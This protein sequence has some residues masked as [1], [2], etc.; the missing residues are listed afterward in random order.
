M[1]CEKTAQAFCDCKAELTYLCTGCVGSHWSTPGRHLVTS[2][3]V[4]PEAHSSSLSSALDR[5]KKITLVKSFLSERLKQINREHREYSIHLENMEKSLHDSLSNK[6]RELHSLLDLN[7]GKLRREVNN[8]QQDIQNYHEKQEEA[9]SLCE[10]LLTQAQSLNG[11]LTKPIGTLMT[12]CG[13]VETQISNLQ[14]FSCQ[15]L[16]VL[17]GGTPSS[18][19]LYYFSDL[20]ESFVSFDPETST[21]TDKYLPYEG[22]VSDDSSWCTLL[23]GDVFVCGG[24]SNIGKLPYSSLLR[25]ATLSLEPCNDLL[26]ARSSHG[27]VQFK[28]FVFVFGGEGD[29]GCALSSTECYVISDQSWTRKTALEQTITKVGVAV[30]EEVIYVSGY[31]TYKL[32]AYFPDRD[33]FRPLSFSFP[34]SFLSSCLLNISKGQT[35]RLLILRGSTVLLC[36][37]GSDYDLKVTHSSEQSSGNVVW[38]VKGSAAQKDNYFYVFNF[39]SKSVFEVFVG[40]VR[41]DIAEVLKEE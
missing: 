32:F 27:I 7:V 31:N 23:S 24:T 28:D 20:E 36:E 30:F 29:T 38:E 2:L 37:P 34:H 19:A 18:T 4:M 16:S 10:S 14:C 8:L 40:G 5:R 9:T 33:S 22:L 41:V 12:N 1:L 26:T 13:G 21:P 15:G 3:D 6:F 11:H 25:L 39:H 35:R 17:I